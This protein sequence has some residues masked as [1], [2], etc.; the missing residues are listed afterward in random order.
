MNKIKRSKFFSIS[1]ILG[2]SLIGIILTTTINLNSINEKNNLNNSLVNQNSVN[3]TKS[4]VE[5]KPLSSFNGQITSS[6]IDSGKINTD[7]VTDSDGNYFLTAKVN[8]NASIVKLNYQMQYL[9][10]WTY[11]TSSNYETRQIVADTDDLGF[12]YALLV[13]NEV[14]INSTDPDA[15]ANNIRFTIENPALVVQLYDTGS[16]FEQRNIYNLGLPNFAINNKS[17]LSSNVANNISITDTQA[18]TNIWDHIY[19]EEA[20]QENDE[21][22]R[23]SFI[24]NTRNPNSTANNQDSD[25]IYL[26]DDSKSVIYKLL[27]KN[28]KK[29]N[30]SIDSIDQDFYILKQLYLNNANNM[31]YL[32]DNA[33]NTKMILI[34]GG[35]AYQSFWFYDFKIN[36][37]TKNTSYATPL[38]YANYDFDHTGKQHSNDFMYGKFFSQNRRSNVLKDAF[39]LP[40][41]QRNKISNLAWFIGGAKTINL[42]SK[43]NNQSHSYVFL[44][45]MQPNVSDFD[46]SFVTKTNLTDPIKKGTYGTP[47]HVSVVK[48]PSTTSSSS[49]QNTVN[50]RNTNFQQT[51][52]I[53][54][55]KYQNKEVLVSS[56]SIN[57]SYQEFSSDGNSSYL[58]TY[59]S[60]KYPFSAIQSLTLLPVM[61]SEIAALIAFEPQSD[62]STFPSEKVYLNT[63]FESTDP[64]SINKFSLFNC[65]KQGNQFY[66]F[67]FNTN[68]FSL[69]TSWL[70]D[71]KSPEFTNGGVQVTSPVSQDSIGFSRILLNKNPENEANYVADG[72]KNAASQKIIAFSP[73]LT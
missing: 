18:A 46:A 68:F 26:N 73:Q 17:T 25:N 51:L 6:S 38:L 45:M 65:I 72:W 19:V 15:I 69:P 20:I 16:S 9:Y 61:T 39:Y 5:P 57:A 27:G 2:I 48:S 56:S 42:V 43:N 60:Y 50:N 11:N 30:N 21:N 54:D 44:A 52:Q 29:E 1:S 70:K 71:K 34:F 53:T 10:H 36:V 33:S 59:T 37:S 40:F 4:T 63:F 24:R 28:G 23:L 55:D 67:R 7:E 64:Y 66:K 12:Y 3:L 14:K 35:N 31:V 22:S 13:H 41:M 32:K 49:T 8:N 58:N 47:D 62:A